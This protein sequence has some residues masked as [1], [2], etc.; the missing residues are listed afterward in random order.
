MKSRVA[1]VLSAVLACVPAFSQ[2]DIKQ[3]A[4]EF[5]FEK[6]PFPS[7]HASTVVELPNNDL[8][9][10]WFGGKDE[11]DPSVGIW[12]ARR[13]KAGWSPPEVIA[14]EPKVPCW[15]PVLFRGGDRLWLYYKVGQNPD[16]WTGAS[17][18]S[19]DGGKTWSDPRLLPAGLL[20]PVR[21]KPIR[22]A[23]GEI[24]AGSSVESYRAWTGWAE[25]SKD[26]GDTWQRFGPLALPD[27]NCGLIQPTVWEAEPGHVIALLRARRPI[28]F[29]CRAESLDGGRTWTPA[30]KTQLSNP[31]SGID[32][33]KLSD[34]RVA[35]VYNPTK[36]SRSPLS[37]AV[38]ADNGG[39]WSP[40]FNLETMFGEF[41]YPAI[42]QTADGLV[43]VTYTWQR[44]RIKHVALEIPR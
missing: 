40:P 20:G 26:G 37:V 44:L 10:A 43:H 34:G 7:C 24:L 21:A 18:F 39:T 15:N 29:I 31:S 16:A 30:R 42:I 14:T 17:R 2:A 36:T 11:G 38:S 33:V 1:F 23:N 8:A 5:V 19:T 35:L 32:A 41:S 3:V 12:M 6:A 4:A 13:S 22:L 28:G 9:C 25:I 27:E